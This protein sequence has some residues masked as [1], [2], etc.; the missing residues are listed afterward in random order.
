MYTNIDWKLLAVAAP[1]S[2]ELAASAIF[3]TRDRFRLSGDF[4]DAAASTAKWSCLRKRRAIG[5]ETSCGHRR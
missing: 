2:S 5:G 3:G 4:N 1:A